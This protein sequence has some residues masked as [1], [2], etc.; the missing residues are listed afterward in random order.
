[1][2]AADIA[3]ALGELLTAYRTNEHARPAR[4]RPAARVL[5]PDGDR[6]GSK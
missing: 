3:A 4:R 6:R 1:M 5:I 2:N